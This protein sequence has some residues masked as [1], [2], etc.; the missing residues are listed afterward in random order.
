VY[1]C[2]AYSLKQPLSSIND[3]DILQSRLVSEASTQALSFSRPVAGRAGRSVFARPAM[4]GAGR[5]AKADTRAVKRQDAD[6]DAADELLFYR[7]SQ[8]HSAVQEIVPT[9]KEAK[10]AAYAVAGEIL[11]RELRLA[12]REVEKVAAAA[13]AHPATVALHIVTL[14]YSLTTTCIVSALNFLSTWLL[15]H[16][17]TGHFRGILLAHSQIQLENAL[18]KRDQISMS[19]EMDRLNRSAQLLAERLRAKSM[20]ANMLQRKVEQ[21]ETEVQ[22]A[23][24]FAT[25]TI[26]EQLARE[27]RAELEEEYRVKHS[28][29]LDEVDRWEATAKA[30]TDQNTKLQR[31]VGVINPHRQAVINLPGSQQSILKLGRKFSSSVKEP[32]APCGAQLD[33]QGACLHSHRSLCARDSPLSSQSQLST[34]DERIMSADDYLPTVCPHTVYRGADGASV[35]GGTKGRQM[36]PRSAPIHQQRRQAPQR[37]V[38]EP[39]IVRHDGTPVAL[40]PQAFIASQYRSIQRS[41]SDRTSPGESLT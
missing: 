12:K 10:N 11:E 14:E 15:H 30:L 22:N 31:F 4:S 6:F 5:V 23:I 21:Y 25:M 38:L 29:L 40:R 39:A 20:E 41:V 35:G 34:V 2:W 7:A 27:V 16:G 9:V 28:A 33:T 8:L 36:R 24:S 18:Y 32:S 1:S 37:G 3:R 19:A 13:E 26:R 17:A